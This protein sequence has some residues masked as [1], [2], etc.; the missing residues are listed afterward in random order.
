MIINSLLPPTSFQSVIS[1]QWYIVTTDPKL[2]WIVVD[3]KYSWE[4]LSK[5][6]VQKEFKN[7]EKEVVSLPKKVEKQTFSVEGSKGK[8]YEVINNSG[9][10]SCSCPAYGF[11]R[12]R[13]CKHIKQI[14][15]GERI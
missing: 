2:G 7:T 4:E 9:R 3:R 15:D 6:W 14:K 8:T 10:W 13:D 11:S 12:G 5:M 1:G